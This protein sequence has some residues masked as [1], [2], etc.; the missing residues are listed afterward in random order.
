MGRTVPIRAHSEAL[1]NS[2]QG[3]V[4]SRHAQNILRLG[5]DQQNFYLNSTLFV[6]WFHFAVGYQP[7]MDELSKL[8]YEGNLEVLKLKIRENNELATK[9][10]EVI[11]KFSLFQI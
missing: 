8:A 9:L 11:R 6:N 4:K 2:D 10:D 3:I 1:D 7:N 5:C